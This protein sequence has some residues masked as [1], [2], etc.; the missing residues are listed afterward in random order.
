MGF[1][2]NFTE[3][4]KEV[5]I[6]QMTLRCFAE[7]LNATHSCLYNYVF[8]KEAQILECPSNLQKRICKMSQSKAK[9]LHKWLACDWN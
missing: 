3:D 7:V 2:L 1:I 6:R 5:V 9:Q 8:I 4:T